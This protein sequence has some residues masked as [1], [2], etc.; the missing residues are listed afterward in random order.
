[1]E[2]TV[3]WILSNWFERIMQNTCFFYIFTL[4]KLI[5]IQISNG[6]CEKNAWYWE[7]LCENVLML[8]SENKASQERTILKNVNTK[9]S[10]Q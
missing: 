2:A 4:L 5:P 8:K 9:I 10:T 6:L 3:C 1:M 7:R